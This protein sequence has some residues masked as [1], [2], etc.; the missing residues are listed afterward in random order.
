MSIENAFNKLFAEMAAERSA[1]QMTLGELIVRL[2]SLPG[3]MKLYGIEAN[4]DSY[5]GYYSDLA[6]PPAAPGDPTITVAELLGV[7]LDAVGRTFD[8]YKG[9]EFTMT[10]T[11]PLWL[12]HYGNCGP[13][14]MALNDDGTFE[15]QED[16]Y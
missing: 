11:T 12:A 13:K 9:G 3:E 1:S 4:P 7:C 8:G 2:R 6:F 16:E 15:T 5:R 10:K 14:I